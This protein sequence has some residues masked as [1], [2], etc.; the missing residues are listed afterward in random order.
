MKNKSILN[1]LLFSIFVFGISLNAC[2][3]K[4][5]T[6]PDT[7]DSDADTTVTC[8]AFEKTIDENPTPN[9]LIGTLDGSTNK[10]SVMFS[11][12]N[13]MPDG[14]LSV[15]PTT[16]DLT[17]A[18]NSLF[19][20]DVNPQIT[21]N[22]TVTNGT[23]SNICTITINLKKKE[24]VSIPD[25]GTDP[26][27]TK[28]F[29]GDATLKTQEDVDTF[30]ASGWTEITGKLAISGSAVTDLS[31]L[32]SITKVGDL[33]IWWISQT[34]NVEGLCNL[35]EVE[36][37]VE[38][39]NCSGLTSLKGLERL[40]S[41]GQNV[42]IAYCKNLESLNALTSLE[43][44]GFLSG[45]N[46]VYRNL[47]IEGLDK[48]QDFT[49]LDKLAEVRELKILKNKS[50][51]TMSGFT[52][53]TKV[54]NIFIEENDALTTTTDLKL[55]TIENRCVINLNPMLTSLDIATLQVA[56]EILI[57][58]NNSLTDVS[59]FA[60]LSGLN[61][62]AFY[63]NTS[64]AGISGFNAVVTIGSGGT[65]NKFY[66]NDNQALTSITGFT[67]LKSIK[68]GFGINECR[69][70][71]SIGNFIIEDIEG[72]LT[73]AYTGVSNLSG[74][75]NLNQLGVNVAIRNNSSLT[76]F[77]ALKTLVSG[78]GF[79]GSWYVSN[80]SANPTQMDVVNNCP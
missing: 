60:N 43:V 29:G 16:G 54:M 50:L 44:I 9:F 59:G 21:A 25:C 79:S 6:T 75:D 57:N 62:L 14:A 26:S 69:K 71:S 47:I 48:L 4:D 42:E 65:I 52:N 33:S 49:G 55:E 68:G 45:G 64:L 53:L 30:A 56:G 51:T 3:D 19:V 58:N 39:K 31:N 22:Y 36:G 12:N 8:S 34:T 18:D 28:V 2:K 78:S 74:L 72:S 10:G 63:K 73:I 27:Y 17:V 11:I 61:N 13:Q 37:D 67:K 38:I 41:V 20:K 7:P 15:D 80:N 32:R 70:L 35:Q 66:I 5:A 23:K 46:Y 1:I 76:D 24:V 77:C 40:K